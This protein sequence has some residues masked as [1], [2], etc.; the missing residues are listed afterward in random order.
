MLSFDRSAQR[1]WLAQLQQWQP[2]S[3]LG[4]LL[5]ISLVFALLWWLSRYLRRPQQPDSIKLLSPLTK[6]WPK[7][8]VSSFSEYLALL[9]QQQPA[10]T[11][12]LQTL[13][14]LYQRWQFND[15]KQ[16]GRAI[17]AQVQQVIHVVKQGS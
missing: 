10:A 12:E 17:R 8:P 1:Q 13:A 11:A 9:Q 4:M 16:L 5:T 7:S 2:A 14:Q 6:R 15:E 3:E